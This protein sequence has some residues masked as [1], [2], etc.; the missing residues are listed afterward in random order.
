MIATVLADRAAPVTRRAQAALAR[1]VRCP[2]LVISSPDDKIT[3]HADARAL[4]K[5]TGGQLFSLA[6]GGHNPQARKPVAVNLALRD[7]VQRAIT[8]DS[9][10]LRGAPTDA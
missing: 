4:A 10:E 9:R 2:V 7:F 8:A 6:D 5:L 1:Q 3:A